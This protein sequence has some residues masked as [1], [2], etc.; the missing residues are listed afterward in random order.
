MECSKTENLS[1]L[2]AMKRTTTDDD[3]CENVKRGSGNYAYISTDICWPTITKYGQKEQWFITK[4]VMNTPH[5][6]E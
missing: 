1:A 4:D 5:F 6:T 3:L 2:M